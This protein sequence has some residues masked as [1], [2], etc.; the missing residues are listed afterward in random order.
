MIPKIIHF[1]W[2][3]DEQYPVLIK[4]CIASWK[5]KLPGYDFVHWNTEK[6]NL[7]DKRRIDFY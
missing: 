4:N 5:K 3:S 2:L 7:D 6:F 1:C